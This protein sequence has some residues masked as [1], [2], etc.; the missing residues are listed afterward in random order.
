METGAAP[1][2]VS[3]D[4]AVFDCDAHINDPL[5]IWEYVPKSQRELVRATYWKTDEQAWLNGEKASGGGNGEYA[6]AGMYNP[7]CIAGPQMNKKIVRRLASMVPLTPAQ[8][9]YLE[10]KGATDPKARVRDLDLM[11]ID[12]VLVIPTKVIQNLPFAEN[13]A[14]VD[15]F[16]HAYN[17]FARDWCSH[18]KKRLYPAALLPLQSPEH[19]VR[20]LERVAG[21]GFPVALMRPFDAAGRYPNDLGLNGGGFGLGGA[22]AVTLDH[23]FRSFEETGVV[24]GM[25]TFPAHHPP[26]TAGPGLLASPGELVAYAGADSQTL[27]FIFE[28]QVWLAQVLLCGFLD[29]YPRLHM[30]VFES[31]SQWLPSFLAS[32]DRLFELY[33]N[34]RTWEAT[35]RPSEAFHEQCVISFESDETQTMRQWEYFGDVGI[36][37]S[38]A[39]HHDGADSWSAIREMR[40]IGVPDDVQ[41]KLLGGN[42]R[43]MYNIDAQV[44][45]MDEPAPLP[46]PDWF[47]GGPE[48]DEWA[49][50]QAH[51]R[52]VRSE[53]TT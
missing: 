40:S 30:A 37:A 46:R 44:F 43:R 20:E 29:R 9:D 5:E 45:V 27:S 23:L 7:I 33:A 36:W 3:K 32:C 24:L 47:P 11:G 16:C 49:E 21:R 17:D 34:E 51:P 4:F 41:A 53:P 14:G 6:P 2:R 31:N 15:V 25:H 12:Q 22:P 8:R 35:R 38:D 10:H 19:A 28:I 50:Q 13:V 52:R 42:A 1:E 18:D 48:L 39:Y 26:S